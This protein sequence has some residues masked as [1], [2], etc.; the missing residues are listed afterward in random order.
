MISIYQLLN[1]KTLG[2][3]EVAYAFFEIKDTKKKNK[4][5]SLIDNRS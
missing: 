4:L 3:T 5:Q 1:G 2:R